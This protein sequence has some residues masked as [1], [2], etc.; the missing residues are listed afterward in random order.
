M[1]KKYLMKAHQHILDTMKNEKNK[2]IIG[3]PLWT[4]STEDDDIIDDN[5]KGESHEG[6]ASGGIREEDAGAAGVWV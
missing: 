3:I 6:A 5:G 1:G 4:P 2:Y